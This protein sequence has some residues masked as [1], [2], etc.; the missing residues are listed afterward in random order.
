[1]IFL[2]QPKSPKTQQPIKFQLLPNKKK[3]IFPQKIKSNK[4]KLKIS[5]VL[6][7]RQ[8]KIR[9]TKRVIIFPII[10][11]IPKIRKDDDFDGDFEE[12]E[13]FGSDKEEPMKDPPPFPPK[14]PSPP[15]QLAPD[16]KSGERGSV[17]LP[18]S[19]VEE[20]AFSEEMKL[21]I[22]RG[23]QQMKELIAKKRPQFYEY[24]MAKVSTENFLIKKIA[25]L[26]NG[27]H[28]QKNYRK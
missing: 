15:P 6:V 16:T 28:Q 22:E 25:S 1:M 26:R 24:L 13:S 23:F 21:D 20:R 8:K 9:T 19:R 18:H 14:Q 17:V 2:I 7:R 3:D 4:T 10:N 5:N 27:S 12:L 11:L